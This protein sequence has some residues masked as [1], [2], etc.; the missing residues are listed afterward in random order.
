MTSA[1]AVYRLNRANVVAWLGLAAIAVYFAVL[2]HAVRA[3]PYDEWMVLLLV[4]ALLAVGTGIIVA[5]TRHDDQPLTTL[6]VVALVVK[7][8]ASFVR[9][10]VAFSLYG[11]GDATLYDAAGTEIAESF[12]RGELSLTDL[13]ALRQG[14]RFIDDLTGADLRADRPEPARRLPRLL[15]HR[16]LGPVP[17]PPRRPHRAARR[18]AS[19]ATPCSCSSSRRWCSGRRASA[20]RR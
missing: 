15:V 14:T 11:S 7:L 2:T 12:H 20:R 5:V 3:W 19:A 6:I 13:L 8:A 17:V 4:P 16:V 9:Y 18:A 1:S 10:Y